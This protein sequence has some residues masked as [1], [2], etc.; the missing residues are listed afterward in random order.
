MRQRRRHFAYKRGGGRVRGE[1]VFGDVAS[2]EPR[3]DGIGAVLGSEPTPDLA[4]MVAEDCRLLLDSLGDETLRNVA[5]WTLEGYSTQE[6]AEK[7]GCV[8]RSV[9]RKLERIREKWARAKESASPLPPGE[10]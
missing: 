4:N 5:L 7:L 1:S 9:E 3:N 6:I 10:G 2:G 8:R